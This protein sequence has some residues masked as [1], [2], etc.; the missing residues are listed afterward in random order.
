MTIQRV[1]ISD[2]VKG[3][4]S[5]MIRSGRIVLLLAVLGGAAAS[6]ARAQTMVLPAAHEADVPSPSPFTVPAPPAAVPLLTPPAPPMPT[7]AP[8]PPPGPYF[9]VDPLLDRPPLPPPGWFAE[10]DVGAVIPH[11][12]NHLSGQVQFPGAASA[13][14]VALPSAGLDWTVFPRVEAGYRL[15]SGFG[16]VSLSFRFLDTE[17]N[18]TVG[19]G[20]GAAVLHSRLSFQEAGLDYSNNET[21]LWPNWDMKWTVGVRLLYTF[22]DSRADESPA[23]S[24]IIEQRDSNW[25]AGFGPHV[26]LELDRQIGCTG[27]S[28]V[29]RGEGSLYLGRLRQAFYETSAAGLNAES[30]IPVSQ[31]VPAAGFFAGFRWQP[32]QWQGAE[33]YLGYQYEHWW[34]LGKNNNTTSSGELDVQGFFVRAALSF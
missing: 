13:D 15:P 11:V 10:V 7:F 1:A 30:S 26:G 23:G 5:V 6:T 33:F 17:G 29:L 18:G 31:A 2:S 34:D 16:A 12:K 28:F 19:G 22:F 24:T 25:Y 3:K 8:A 32:P 20:D 9:E 14:T 21:S 4:E 27:L